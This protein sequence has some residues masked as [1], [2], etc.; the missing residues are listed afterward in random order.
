MGEEGWTL[1]I[2]IL[3][4]HYGLFESKSFFIADLGL[5]G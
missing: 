1:N 2:H 4:A 5:S 3:F